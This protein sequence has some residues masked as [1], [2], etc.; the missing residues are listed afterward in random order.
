MRRSEEDFRSRAEQIFG[1]CQIT[2]AS[3]I[4]EMMASNSAHG[5]LQSGS[6]IKS[7]IGIFERCSS[8]ALSESLDEV[9]RLVDH[10]GATWRSAMSGV[11]K[12]LGQHMSSANSQL[13]RPVSIADGRGTLSITHVVEAEIRDIDFRLREKLAEF[14]DGWTAPL[15]RPWKDRHLFVYALLLLAIGGFGGALL[16]PAKTIMG[17]FVGMP[18]SIS[19]SQAG[20]RPRKVTFT[21]RDNIK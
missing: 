8:D 9:G 3:Q 17:R 11:S 10:R 20:T 1:R 15:E 19:A 14:Q 13:Q 5:R 4:E 12:A 21:R 6:T 16:T 7:A 2:V 18:A